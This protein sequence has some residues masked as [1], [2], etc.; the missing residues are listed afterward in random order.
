MDKQKKLILFAPHNVMAHYLRSIEIAKLLNNDFDIMFIYSEE[1]G[2]FVEENGFMQTIPVSSKFDNVVLKTREFDFSWI[3]YKSVSIVVK[4]LVKII[5]RY[6]PDLIFGD[7]NLGLR[8]ACSITKTKLAV[9]MNSY[10]TNYYDGYRPVPHNHRANEYSSR[11]SPEMWVKIVRGVEKLTLWDVHRAFRRIRIRYGLKLYF[12]LFDEFAGDLNFLCDDVNIFPIMELKDNYIPV[13]PVLFRTSQKEDEL[14]TILRNTPKKP[15]IFISIGSTGRNIVP[16][17]ISESQLS[18]YIVIVSGVSENKISGNVIFRKFVNFEEIASFVDLVIC[19]GGNGTMYQSV[20]A[21][22]KIIAVP[23]MFEQ[24]WNAHA[25]QLAGKCSVL[26]PEDS[27]DKFLNEIKRL[28]SEE[29]KS[30]SR[31]YEM[32]DLFL[33]KIKSLLNG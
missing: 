30:E 14:L 21:G 33:I 26:Y 20:E 23:A 6:N 5:R 25:F 7:T 18:D 31:K 2:R 13:G 9:L 3:N 12:S 29:S 4:E 19:H 32:S 27:A 16:D 24:E 8:V 11:V 28:I 22:K 10:L 1:Y 17:I 15:I